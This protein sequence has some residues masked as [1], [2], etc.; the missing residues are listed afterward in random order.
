[1]RRI[2]CAFLLVAAVAGCTKP[3]VYA[4]DEEIAAVSY[5][6]PEEPSL[7]LY[8]MINN[9]SGEGA[10]TALLIT[11][12][13]QVIFDPAGSFYSEVTPERHDVVF[14]ITPSMEKAYRSAHARSTFH[15]VSQK[16]DVSPEQAQ[17]AYQLALQAGP[18]PDAFCTSATSKLLSQVPGFEGLSSTMYPKNL[19][20]Q[21]EEVPGVQTSRYYEDDSPDL[22]KALAEGNIAVAQQ[23]TLTQ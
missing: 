13:E 18:V 20:A 4:T 12:S 23:A 21:I 17:T 15:V 22:Q 11:A 2:V 7:T 9:R 19:M 16:I 5:R 14:G 3:R 10:H 6:N 8:T 1:M